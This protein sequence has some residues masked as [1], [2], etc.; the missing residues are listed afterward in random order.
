MP[1]IDIDI[2]EG[3]I[4]GKTTQALADAIGKAF[5][6]DS[7][8]VW[9]RARSLPAA[10]YAENGRRDAP[11]P[12]FVTITAS[13]PPQGQ[14]LRRIIAIIVEDVA[15]ITKRDAEHVHVEFAPAAK[16]RIAFGGRLVE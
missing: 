8:R 5:G 11:Q 6:A 12:V 2:V 4:A 1:I 13:R 16:G 10:A 9:V 7:G 15:R 3:T 14:E